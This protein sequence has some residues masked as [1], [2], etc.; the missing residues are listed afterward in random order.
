MTAHLKTLIW[1]VLWGLGVTGVVAA[2]LTRPFTWGANA[3]VI[4][5]FFAL[6]VVLVAQRC[7]DSPPST[8]GRRRWRQPGGEQRAF[9]A[10]WALWAG[11]VGAVIG[12]ELFC[13]FSLPRSAHPTISS[14]VDLLDA[15]PVGR[16]IA[17]VAWL[18]LGWYLVTR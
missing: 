13:Y 3:A 10:R 18:T 7:L 12:W 17:F 14:M 6:M 8:L 1:A 15:N 2:S 11:P 9:G 4:A 16:G 5:G